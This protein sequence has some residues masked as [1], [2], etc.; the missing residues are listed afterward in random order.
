MR[1]M[2]EFKANGL[3]EVLTAQGRK[4]RWLAAKVGISESHLSRIVSGD[5]L[6]SRTLAE[7]IA[8][9]LQIPL[10]LAF[11]FT[12]RSDSITQEERVA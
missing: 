2:T 3:E 4:A 1:D 11:E 5:R 12:K 6:A 9:T 8:A 10:F 7:K